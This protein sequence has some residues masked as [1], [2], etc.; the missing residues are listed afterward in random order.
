MLARV[1]FWLGFA[2]LIIFLLTGQYM[3]F[4][5]NALQDL[6]DRPRMFY[7]SAHIYLL[8]ASVLNLFLGAY[9]QKIEH[10]VIGKLQLLISLLVLLS[11]VMFLLGF[12]LE[13]QYA[14]EGF[15]RP[16]TGWA[17]YF[18]FIA[19]VLLCIQ[20]FLRHPN[21]KNKQENE[22]PRQARDDSTR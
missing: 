6:A 2:G 18:L 11:P 3:G 19:A 12:F 21:E 15:E 4:I 10:A 9:F 7:R 1:H 22:I 13:Y 17:N 8:L 20:E 14:L 16:I 5:H